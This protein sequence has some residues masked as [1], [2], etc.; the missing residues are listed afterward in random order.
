MRAGKGTQCR[1][2]VVM[3]GTLSLC[4]PYALN[5]RRT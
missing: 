5:P 4:P 2:R 1:A 3:A